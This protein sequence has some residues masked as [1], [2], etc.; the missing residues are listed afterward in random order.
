MCGIAGRIAADAGARLEAGPVRA[1]CEVMSHRGPDGWNVFD[2]GQAVLGHRRLSIVDLEGGSQ[3][4]SG[5]DEQ[6]WV[7]FNGEIY[8]HQ[9][10]RAELQARGH[11]FRTRSDTE[12]LVHGWEEWGEALPT[13]LRGM[14]AFCIWDARTRTAFLARDRVGI[15][16]IYYARIGRDLVFASE[17]KALFCH[18]G[19]ARRLDAQQLAAYLALRY[20]PGP[21][22]L[23]EGVTR[24]QPGNAMVFREGQARTFSYWDVPFDSEPESALCEQEQV[25]RFAQL[26]EESVRLR[27][28]A[29]VPV[30]VFLSGGLDSTAVAWAMK[31]NAQGEVKSFSVGY[32]GDREG[33]LAYARLAAEKLGTVHREVQ[34]SAELF[35]ELLPQ[36]AWHL[37][38]PVADAACVPLFY[39]SRRAREE[40]TVVLSGEGADEVLAGYPIYRKMLALEQGRKLAP[41]VDLLAPLLASASP[42]PKLSKYLD[43]ATRELPDR[44]RGVSRAFSDALVEQMLRGLPGARASERVAPLYARTH[45]LSPLRRMLYADTKAWLPDDLLIKADKMSMAASIELRVPFLDH[46]L[47]ALCWSLPDSLRLRGKTGK[48]LLRRAMA[49]KIPA[50]IITRKKMGFPVPT[51]AWLAGPLHEQLRQSLLAGKSACRTLFSTEIIKRLLDEHRQ[52]A[53]DRTEEL[54]A[55]WIFESWHTQFVAAPELSQPGRASA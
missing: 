50:E 7:T 31:Q 51:G 28:M 4:L 3:P 54:Y 42:N 29:D 38:E 47:L 15:K 46:E 26:F 40:V 52:G 36:L 55:L 9:L 41:L 23:F 24:L 48:Y 19:L 45:G 10:L 21:Q 2:G 43:L 22:T 6:V 12:V 14:F 1:M 53:V 8:N 44:Y 30:G 27:L 17:A 33:E 37:D 49:G 18:P 35:G 11:T 32:E 16:P 25:E 34:V 13:R 39:L 20:V 5:C